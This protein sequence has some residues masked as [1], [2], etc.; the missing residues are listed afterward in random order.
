M[1]LVCTIG[2]GDGFEFDVLVFDEGE[3][4]NT[5]GRISFSSSALSPADWHT[6]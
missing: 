2:I 6:R 1:T 4:E 3:L 5:Q